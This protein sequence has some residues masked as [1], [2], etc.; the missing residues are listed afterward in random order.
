MLSA[1]QR[2]RKKDPEKAASYSRKY[3]AEDP[4]KHRMAQARWRENNPE[5]AKE[6]EKEWCNRNQDYLRE[7][8]ANR[9]RRER[10]A[11]GKITRESIKFLMEAQQGKCA[12]CKS[13]LDRSFHV[14]HI[15]PLSTGGNNHKDN[16]QLLCAPCNL[17]KGAK[18][19]VDFMQSRGFLL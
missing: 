7:K 2:L 19:P 4:S 8:Y 13:E 18:H 11:E 12:C 1:N 14:D 9:R 5:R 3:R 6:V 15:I 10:S 17:S 16:L